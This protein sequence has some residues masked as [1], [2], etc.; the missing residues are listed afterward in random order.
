MVKETIEALDFVFSM[1]K[2]GTKAL[3]DGKF[4]FTDIP[5]L[6]SPVMK[7]PAAING[8]KSIPAELAHLSAEDQEAIKKFVKENFD[9]AVPAASFSAPT[10]G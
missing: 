7:L 5:L 4:G 1:Q 3:E 8:A 2:A 9:T 10:T 6:W